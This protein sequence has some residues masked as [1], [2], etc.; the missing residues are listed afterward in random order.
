MGRGL[1]YCE[2]GRMRRRIL[3]GFGTQRR[4]AQ[5]F[6]CCKVSSASLRLEVPGRESR[7]LIDPGIVVDSAVPFFRFLAH[8]Y[9]DPLDLDST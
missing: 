8:Q 9:S 6:Q 1:G 5:W 7:G 3:N 4:R 2:D